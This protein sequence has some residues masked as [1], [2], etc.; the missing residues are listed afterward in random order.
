MLVKD[1]AGGDTGTPQRMRRAVAAVGVGNAIE[2]Y[3]YA[4]YGSFAAVLGAT[5]FPGLDDA[6][7]L[8][9]AFAVYGTALLI[10]PLGALVFG[11]L[12]D[13]QGRRPTMTLVIVVTSLATAGVGLLP[14]Q[15]AIGLAAPALLVLFRLLQGLGAG[16]ELGVSSVF[17]FE[18]A[19]RGRRGLVGSLQIATM[20]LGMALGMVVAAVLTTAAGGRLVESGWWRLAF[21]AALPLGL[22]G[23]YV[24]TRVDETSEFLGR[25]TARGGRG[26]W[27]ALLGARRSR[28]WRGFAIVAA[29][30]LA[31]NVFFVFLPNVVA[32][33]HHAGATVWYV[34]G[35]ALLVTA[36]STILLGHLSDR[37]GRRPV[38]GSCAIALA[39]LAVP[40]TW[41]AD[42][43]V[44]AM[45]VAQCL[46]GIT[47][48]GVLS[49]TLL[50]EAF[51][52]ELRTTGVAMTAGLATALIGGTAPAVA[53]LMVTATRIGVAPAFYVTA[54]AAIAG[55]AVWRWEEAPARA[56][57]ARPSV[58]LD[59]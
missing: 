14:G 44:G 41:L 35:A 28:L 37:A 20:C 43:S 54:V 19:P 25:E 30:S 2:W 40:L 10:R 32:I 48:G 31:Y 46:V 11:R 6:T 8:L 50:A 33:R 57:T 51:P 59:G 58:A 13:T 55:V 9:L 15:L 21:L 49:I 17:L 34:S 18:H 47:I 38:V 45:L 56:A 22:I 5:F 52:P 26:P 53:Q 3:D 29:G 24:R 1:G 16:G 27:R 42:Q 36:L 12:G 23:W 4:I 7:Q 39:V